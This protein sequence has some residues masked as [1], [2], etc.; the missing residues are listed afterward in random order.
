V[1]FGHSVPL[2]FGEDVG[3]DKTWEEESHRG[4]KIAR[5]TAAP[6]GELRNQWSSSSGSSTV[7]VYRDPSILRLFHHDCELL[8]LSS[9]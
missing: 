2:S 4:L 8:M 1:S 9:S 7:F 6:T 5:L 3:I